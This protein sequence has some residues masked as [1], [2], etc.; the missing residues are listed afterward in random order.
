MSQLPKPLVPANVDLRDFGYMPLDALRLRDSDLAIESSPEIFRA[1]V[2]LWCASWHQVPAGSLPNKDKTLAEYARAGTRWPRIR[3]EVLSKW[4]Q[5]SDG[6]IY[7][8]VVAEKALE[9]QAAKEAQ[10]ERTRAA[11]EAREAKRRAAAEAR[12]VGN[13]GQR[14]DQRHVVPEEKRDVQ[15]NDSP[16]STPHVEREM[17]SHVV[18]GK[19]REGKG[20]EGKGI[21]KE[22]TSD[23]VGSGEPDQSGPPPFALS[24]SPSAEYAT[25]MTAKDKVWALGVPL[26]GAGERP[27]LGRLAKT[28]GEEVLVQVLTDATLQRPVEPKAWVIAACEAKTKGKPTSTKAANSHPQPTTR[29]VLSEEPRPDWALK[30]GFDNRFEAENAGCF[31]HNASEFRGGKPVRTERSVA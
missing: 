29:D 14:D 21:G 11:T 10:R 31:E 27:L 4:V 5:C 2:L 13:D 17:T 3:K 1:S 7:H 12:D 26:L 19:G 8:P 30:A 22:N 16:R 20:R 6:R 18:Q 28:H 15:R 25:P 24:P 23:P 9:A